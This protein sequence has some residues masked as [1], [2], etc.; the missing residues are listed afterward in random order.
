[1]PTTYL[2]RSQKININE[3]TY[4]DSEWGSK[5]SKMLTIGESGEKK[6]GSSFCSSGSCSVHVKLFEVSKFEIVW[7]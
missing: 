5:W 1:M 4:R 2:K 7:K 3:Y 6:Y